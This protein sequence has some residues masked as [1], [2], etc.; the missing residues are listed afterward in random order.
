MSW[1]A[2]R[3][4]SRRHRLAA[5]LTGCSGRSFLWR[6][7]GQGPRACRAGRRPAGRAD[8][9][10]DRR[11][12]APA[13]RNRA[14]VG[15]G[16]NGRASPGKHHR[17]GEDGDPGT[18]PGPGIPSRLG[19]HGTPPAAAGRLVTARA[20]HERPAGW[21]RASPAERTRP[22]VCIP[23]ATEA[24][25]AKCSNGGAASGLKTGHRPPDRRGCRARGTA[26]GP[27]DSGMPGDAVHGPV[28][29]IRTASAGVCPAPR[30]CRAGPACSPDPVRCKTTSPP[31]GRRSSPQ[32]GR[33]PLGR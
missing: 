25:S 10:A 16:A 11:Q 1:V 19:Q 13:A 23:Q 7:G 32:P 26:A 21:R 15:A 8:G 31:P 9:G 33:R 17:D 29:L 22:S 3:R 18:D 14:A 5:W 12:R 20:T 24:G 27:R 4:V 30:P 6:S 2:A 28:P